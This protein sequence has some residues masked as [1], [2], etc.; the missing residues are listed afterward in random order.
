MKYLALDRSFE[1]SRETYTT[2]YSFISFKSIYDN[3]GK[4][5]SI[6]RHKDKRLL[7]F[8]KVLYGFLDLV[9]MH[10]YRFHLVLIAGSRQLKLTKH[11]KNVLICLT[12]TLFLLLLFGWFVVLCLFIAQD[13]HG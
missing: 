5:C 2:K 6:T 12:W 7:L 9:N 10:K 11:I 1:I 4:K 13:V 8:P 3:K